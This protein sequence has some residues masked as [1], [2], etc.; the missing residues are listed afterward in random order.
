MTPVL[1]RKP[2][3]KPHRTGG[4]VFHAVP[5]SNR[6]PPHRGA[7][8]LHPGQAPQAR[9]KPA[10]SNGQPGAKLPTVVERDRLQDR[11]KEKPGQ[12]RQDLN[13]DGGMTALGTDMA[14]N[15]SPAARSRR[16]PAHRKRGTGPSR[17]M[18][19]DRALQ[20]AGHACSSPPGEGDRVDTGES[21]RKPET[22]EGWGWGRIRLAPEA[23][24]A[25]ALTE[26][27][28]ATGTGG[29]R[30]APPDRPRRPPRG[31]AIRT[32]YITTPHITASGRL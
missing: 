13:R 16:P 9:G 4:P 32:R 14:V 22:R 1:S 29:E 26:A 12:S 7:D 8:D 20:A 3:S 31:P 21:H 25:G 24:G 30:T 17:P 27:F 5:C 2:H 10:A 28:L 15:D 19:S 18:V 11:L 6:A 23:M